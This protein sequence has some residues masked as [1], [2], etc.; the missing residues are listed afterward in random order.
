MSRFIYLTKED[1][2]LYDLHE[3]DKFPN[4]N[5]SFM[6]QVDNFSKIKSMM[7]STFNNTFNV[8]QNKYSG[9]INKMIRIINDTIEEYNK[10]T[11]IICMEYI[12]TDEI[13]F[14]CK[15]KYHIKC[16]DNYVNYNGLK[17]CICKYQFNKEKVYFTGEPYKNNSDKYTIINGN[18]L[19]HIKNSDV[20]IVQINNNVLHYNVLIEIGYA[21]GINKPVYLTFDKYPINDVRIQSIIDLCKK[22]LN[23]GN[24]KYRDIRY[25]TIL[26]DLMT[27]YF[28]QKIIN[29]IFLDSDENNTD[30]D[31]DTES[32]SD[33][34]SDSDTES[35]SDTEYSE[36][37]DDDIV[38]RRL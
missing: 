1:N 17:C 38:S 9:D 5:L 10:N 24:Q 23:N 34:E 30:F 33:I 16:L 35:A 2:N 26:H 13:D 31:E 14:C 21:I 37:S 12:E 11:C 15:Q 7:I 25:Y 8:I 4:P 29:D 19:N 20:V 32:D 6:I 28:E 3:T 22:S 18:G 36:I 27:N